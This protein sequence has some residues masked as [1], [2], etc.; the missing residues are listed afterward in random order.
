MSFLFREDIRFNFVDAELFRYRLGGRAVISFQH[1]DAKTFLMK[2]SN[3]GLPP[4][5]CS[6]FTIFG[7]PAESRG[8]A[9]LRIPAMAITIPG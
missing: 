6:T 3:R 4:R 1:N 8:C 5:S 7:Y 2:C 9:E